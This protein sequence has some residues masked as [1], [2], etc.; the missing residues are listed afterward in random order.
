MST[1]LF[2]GKFSKSLILDI[3]NHLGCTP[4]EIKETENPHVA[5]RLVQSHVIMPNLIII[6]I[7]AEYGPTT[8]SEIAWDLRAKDIDIPIVFILPKDADP[9]LRSEVQ[10]LS[11][12][13]LYD[14]FSFQELDLEISIGKRVCPGRGYRFP[15]SLCEDCS[16]PLVPVQL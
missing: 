1:V 4:E 13:F 3:R 2:V 5:S 9:M 11:P 7:T 6:R 10:L 14:E 16:T 8:G 15:C 12:T